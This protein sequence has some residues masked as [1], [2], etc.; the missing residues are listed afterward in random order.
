MAGSQARAV[1]AVYEAH[2]KARRYITLEQC[3]Q[4]VRIVIVALGVQDEVQGFTPSDD[5]GSVE[6]DA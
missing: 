3:E 4:L 1:A 2:K 6:A 5:R